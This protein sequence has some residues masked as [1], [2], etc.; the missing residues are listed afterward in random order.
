MDHQSGTLVREKGML[1]FPRSLAPGDGR[2][3]RGFTLIELMVTIT[4]LS[5]LLMLAVPSFSQWS[6]NTQVRSTAETLQN[7]LRAAKGHALNL[8]RQVVI[9]TTNANPGPNAAPATDGVNWSVQYV[10]LTAGEDLLAKPLFLEGGSFGSSAA[11]ITVAGGPQT[12]CFNSMGRIVANAA[13]GTGLPACT[14]ASA[15]Y[16]VSRTGAVT[17]KD[18]KLHVVVSMAGQI[19]MCDPDRTFSAAT[20]DGCP[21]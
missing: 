19:R 7:G 14:A 11:G 4:L 8:N 21:P 15:T 12:L 20:P 16:V 6:R 1:M 3:H 5:I 10:P 13:P 9:T 18:R 17:G 2:L